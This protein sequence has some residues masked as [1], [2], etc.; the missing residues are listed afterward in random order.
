[1]FVWFLFMLILKGQRLAT[2]SASYEPVKDT[3]G[4]K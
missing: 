4:A 2:K 1:M 3:G